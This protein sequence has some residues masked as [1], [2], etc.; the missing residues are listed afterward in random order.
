MKDFVSALA[1]SI[2]C[3][4]AAESAARADCQ[5]D[6]NATM[7]A[8]LK[9]GPYHVSSKGGVLP[10]ELDAVAPDGFHVKEYAK[11]GSGVSRDEVIFTTKGGWM[12]QAGGKWEA[13]PDAAAAQ[14]VAG[15]NAALAGG[16]KNAAE[17]TCQLD[18]GPKTLPGGRKVTGYYTFKIDIFDMHSGQQVPTAVGLLQGEDGLPAALLLRTKKGDEA[19]D[20]TYDPKIKVEVPVK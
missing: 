10:Y 15:Y 19:Q 14:A 20:I 9:A 1:Y 4:C 11:D 2:V 16:F 3:V 18:Q 8:H 5:S 13:I 12:K 7:A 6:F 17:L